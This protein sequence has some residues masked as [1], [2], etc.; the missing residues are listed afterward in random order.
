[1]SLNLYNIGAGVRFL[2]GRNIRVE[3]MTK[4]D[5]VD[6]NQ[7]RGIGGHVGLGYVF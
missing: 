1:M 5:P 7:F 2:F 4:A 3:I 6:R